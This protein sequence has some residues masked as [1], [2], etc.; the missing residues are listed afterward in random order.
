MVTIKIHGGLGNQM[1]E[2][3]LGRALSLRLGA[4]LF[5]DPASLFDGTPRR[6]VSKRNYVLD[7][8]FGIKPK[9][10]LPARLTRRV[11]LYYLVTA[12]NRY[13]PRVLG[14][15]GYWRY[16]REKAYHFDPSI[17]NL[18]GNLYLNGFWQSEKYFK[19]YESVL[20]KDFAFRHPLP[21]E[22]ARMSAEMASRESVCLHVRRGDNVWSPLSRKLHPLAPVD[23]Y[24]Q[25]V[26]MI[27]A[28]RG[29]DIKVFIFS[30]DTAWCREN[31][32][33]DADHEFVGDEYAGPEGRDHLQLMTLCKHFIIP[34]STFS[35]W[36]AWLSA[37]RGKIVI[38]PREWFRDPSIDTRDAI[39]AGWLRI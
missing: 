39:P 37:N 15:L 3:A 19:E 11:Q 16:V 5:L 4:N 24:R 18:K 30:D 27:K 1:F 34:E 29:A 6:Q 31:L 10:V 25:A 12:F 13:Y 26:A 17:L 8:V 36:A 33:I 7:Q 23:Y 32:P 14:M 9:L 28:K 38:A 2:Y 35:W 21:K 20:R 22:A